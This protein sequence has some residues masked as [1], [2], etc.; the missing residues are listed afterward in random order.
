[1]SS[2]RYRLALIDT[3]ENI[4]AVDGAI[5]LFSGGAAFDAGYSND[6][7]IALQKDEA[8]MHSIVG[9]AQLRAIKRPELDEAGKAEVEQLL[10]DLR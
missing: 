7:R 2:S 5:A 3:P 8:Y 1:M 9:A 6:A 10:L 4:Q